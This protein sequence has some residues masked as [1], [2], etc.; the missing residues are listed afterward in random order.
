L[1]QAIA[2]LPCHS[3]FAVSQ[4]S[5]ASTEVAETLCLVLLL[6]GRFSLN[7][8]SVNRRRSDRNYC[9]AATVECADLRGDSAGREIDLFSEFSPENGRAIAHCKRK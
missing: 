8:F 6:S 7:N 3:R 4:I 5:P 2:R 1:L 9:C